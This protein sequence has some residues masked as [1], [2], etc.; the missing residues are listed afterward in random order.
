MSV[1]LLCRY[2]LYDEIIDVGQ[3]PYVE[4]P[5]NELEHWPQHLG[6]NPRRGPQAE[7]DHQILE[8]LLPPLEPC[9]SASFTVERNCEVG[10]RQVYGREE[11][12]FLYPRLDVRWCRHAE[13]LLPDE[14]VCVLE[15][16]NGS[17]F[18]FC[19]LRSGKVAADH[20]V[21]RGSHLAYCS[22]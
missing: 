3:Y 11:P 22:F 4:L 10:I 12:V 7:H 20:L 18:S 1:A 21:L 2:G 8:G 13:F 5:P 6:E 19:L 15:G 14:P 17:K 9:E 16:N